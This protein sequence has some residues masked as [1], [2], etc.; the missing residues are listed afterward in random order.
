MHWNCTFVQD[1]WHEL[2][3]YCSKVSMFKITVEQTTDTVANTAG[4]Q[5]TTFHVKIQ[6][7]IFNDCYERI[8]LCQHIMTTLGTILKQQFSTSCFSMNNVKDKIQVMQ[9]LWK[10][11]LETCPLSNWQPNW[12]QTDVHH[13]HVYYR[14]IHSLWLEIDK[15]REKH[16]LSSRKWISSPSSVTTDQS[17]PI[18]QNTDL[19]WQ[20]IFTFIS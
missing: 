17:P 3:F 11:L 2:H 8:F 7:F 9:I 12:I 19:M 14:R 18:L 4:Y 1:A 15:N 10:P 5:V 6:H 16:P 13:S 20:A